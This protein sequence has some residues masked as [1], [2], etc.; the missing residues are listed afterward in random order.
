[1]HNYKDKIRL[2]TSPRNLT[3]WEICGW[4]S[5]GNEVNIPKWFQVIKRAIVTL[6]VIQF[7]IGIRRNTTTKRCLYIITQQDAPN[8]EKSSSN[9]SVRTGE[10]SSSLRLRGSNFI[11]TNM[12]EFSCCLSTHCLQKQ[13]FVVLIAAKIFEKNFLIHNQSH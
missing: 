12:Q 10:D 3:H 7:F 13:Y 11:T 4:R 8:E 1:M 2:K 5:Y 6:A 9:V